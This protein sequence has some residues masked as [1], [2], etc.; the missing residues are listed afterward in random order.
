[1]KVE[2]D[3][4]GSPSL[5][6]HQLSV[7]VKQNQKK[8]RKEK[9]AHSHAADLQRLCLQSS[10]SSVARVAWRVEKVDVH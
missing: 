5:I 7:D 1:M 10:I 3:V 8:K 2:V 4:L 9:V 6:S